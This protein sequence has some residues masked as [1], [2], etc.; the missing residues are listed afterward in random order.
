MDRIKIIGLLLIVIF[1]T[2]R[3]TAKDVLDDNVLCR[4]VRVDSSGKACVIDRGKTDGLQPGTTGGI[5]KDHGDQS[6]AVEW[7]FVIARGRVAKIFPDSAMLE[8][9][10][11]KDFVDSGDCFAATCQ[12]SDAAKERTLYRL[13]AY[14]ITFLYLDTKEPVFAYRALRGDND[15]KAAAAAVDSLV[16]EVNRQADLA[17]SVYEGKVRGGIFDGLTLKEAFEKTGRAEVND[18]LEFVRYYPGK[19]LNRAWRFCDVYATWIINKTYS[20]EDEKI[21]FK[22]DALLDET[23][24]LIDRGQ[25]E[26]AMEKLRQALAVKPDYE[27]TQTY[28]GKLENLMRDERIIASDPEDAPVRLE[29][30]RSYYYFHKEAEAVKEYEAAL[31]LGF[32]INDVYL[33]LGYAHTSLG[34]YDEALKAFQVVARRDPRDKTAKK[35]IA[36]AEARRDLARPGATEAQFVLG[37]IKYE[38]G[39]YDQAIGAYQKVLDQDPNSARARDLI[40]KAIQR[41]AAQQ[42]LDW[43]VDDWHQ[44]EY[45]DA[46]EKFNQALAICRE[47]GDDAGAADVLEN[48]GKVHKELKDYVDAIRSFQEIVRLKPAE[49]D[50]YVEIS[51]IYSDNGQTD[52]AIVWARRAIAADSTSAWAHNVLGYLLYPLGQTEEAVEQLK[53]AA[54]IDSTYKYPFYNL[55][56]AYA[57]QGDYAL[58][59]QYFLKAADVDQDY[60][61]A[62]S[63]L[64]NLWIIQECDSLLKILPGDART[65]FRKGRAYYYLEMYDPAIAL[66]DQA[67]DHQ[68]PDVQKYLGYAYTKLEKFDA[69]AAAFKKFLNRDPANANIRNWL[70]WTEAKARL[71]K[72]DR[73][74]NAFYRLAE[75]NIY[76]AE[77]DDAIVNLQKARDLDYD[78]TAVKKLLLTADRGLKAKKEYDNGDLWYNRGDYRQA[79]GYYEAAL[80]SYQAIADLN[81]EI[82]TRSGIAWCY[83]ALY[84]NEQARPQFDRIDTLL[85]LMTDPSK[86]AQN[87]VNS[88]YYYWVAEGETQKARDKY[89]AGLAIYR[90][91]DDF[92]GQAWT[93]GRQAYLFSGDGD[94]K[95]TQA[96]YDR[97]LEIHKNLGYKKG[98]AQDYGSYASLHLSQDDYAPALDF[99]RR[100][101]TLGQALKNSWIEMSSLNTISSIYKDLGDSTSALYY[102]REYLKSATAYGSN[103]DRAVAL[104]EIGLVYYDIVQDYDR[105]LAE[106]QKSL[107]ISVNMNDRLNEGVARSNIGRCY[108]N[109]SDYNQALEYQKQGLDLVLAMRS[110]YTET[111]GYDE[112]GRTYFSM[113]EF[114]QAFD[115]FQKGLTM[116]RGMTM[117][118]VEWECLYFLGQIYE[119]RGQPDSAI[120]LYRRAAKVLLGIR[121]KVGGEE[122]EKSFMSVGEKQG[123]YKRL[124]E[125]LIKQG[126]PDEAIQ[127]LEE[128][129]SKMI[130]DVFGDL[131]PKIKDEQLNQDLARID[132]AQKKKEALQKQLQ[133]EQAKPPEEQNQLK[134][135]N[136]STTLAQT[137]GEFNKLMFQ[138]QMN[139]ENMFNFITINPFSLGDVQEGLPEEAVL[140][141][142]FMTEDKLYIF[143]VQKGR[144]FRVEEVNVKSADL[145]GLVD[146]YLGLIKNAAGAVDDDFKVCSRKLYD[147]LVRPMEDDIRT[148]DIVIIVPF[149][150]LYYLPFHALL[151]TADP[152]EYLIQWKKV[153]YLTS[154][155]WLDIMKKARPRKTESLF[156][157]GDPDGSLPGALNE[158][159][160]LKDSIFTKAEVYTLADATKNRFLADAK[161]F[162]IIHL[163]TH[164]YLEPD[165]MKSYIL[166]AGSDDKLT[167]LDIAGYT[168]LRDRTYL[169]FLSA[170][171]TAIEKGKSNGRE[172]M[173]LA[174]AFT[175]AGPPSLIATLWKIPDVST[176]RLVKIFYEELKKKRGVGDALRDAQLAVIA[177]PQYNHPFYWAGFLLF[178]DYR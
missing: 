169:V 69:A 101:L 155:T 159:K 85:R 149:G 113:G 77:F 30:G 7:S 20:A 91:L 119:N 168:E 83:L 156:A 128:S 109:L 24:D 66:L 67:R 22:A 87:L 105:A 9:S 171:E 123:V 68:L 55:G 58:A 147:Y 31:K 129:K 5:Y 164:G 84:E 41:K 64:S 176:S 152:D 72:N 81:D 75:T 102:G 8:L 4:I 82:A 166:M 57:Q 158:V 157:L 16:A 35:W 32:G 97:M 111:Q 107:N 167:L 136:I 139:N 73:D 118:G 115:H 78:S 143:M 120:E 121:Q 45:A 54:R 135:S 47:I 62:H 33:N 148:K 61:D 88:G 141:E 92:E 52:S 127:Y 153:A 6:A 131:K 70:V 12:V 46:L 103:W 98:E 59:R 178:G 37:Q 71:K 89:D 174:K 122:A 110:R 132:D 161:N 13:A 163:A 43:A 25:Y 17:E 150:L 2:G 29:L 76:D 86:L 11:V 56:M 51:N 173:S 114:A 3:A 96:V 162:N 44:H 60:A 80:L 104:T 90:D 154:S 53:R 146:Y 10:A 28:L 93:L 95:T 140:L 170:C 165:P 172:L 39:E 19:Y 15:G 175:T 34:N 49:A 117:P 50:A 42:Q 65:I 23:S 100:S 144:K 18:F 142:Y 116:A 134:I 130:R 38:E 145:E 79:L 112:L 21:K 99:A 63:R 137:E 36:Y 108:A 106:F 26:T 124:I 133:D 94:Y 48:L 14:G 125:L 151:R 74:P 177:S 1:S 40:G 138:L 126:R 160:V 27:L